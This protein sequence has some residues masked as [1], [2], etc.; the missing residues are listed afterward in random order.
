MN[1]TLQLRTLDALKT[2]AK[3][4]RSELSATGITIG[5]SKSLELL[6]KQHGFKDWNTLH[7]AAGNRGPDAPVFLGQRVNGRYLNQPFQ[8]EIIG[9]Q[10][11]AKFDMFRVTIKFNEPVDIITF[12]G[13]SNFR[14]QVSP[15]I[16]REGVTVEKTSDGSPHLVLEL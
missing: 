2:Q 1:T 3:R 6:A 14:Q 7:A 9:V 16:T 5:H 8:G 12:E 13:M 15:T 4:L 10:L 11:L